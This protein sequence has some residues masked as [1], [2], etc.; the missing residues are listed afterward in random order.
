MGG[1]NNDTYIFDTDLALGTDRIIDTAGI[2]TLDFSATTTRNVSVNLELAG[3]QVINAGLSLRLS[4]S[5]TMENVI[6]GSLNDVILGNSR[7]NRLEGGPGDDTLNGSSGND[8][9]VFDTDSALG[10]DSVEDE[11]GG[12]DILDFS[13]TSTR[14]VDVNLLNGAPQVVNE[15]LTLLLFSAA[16][17][18]Q[19]IGGSLGDR[20][21]GNLLDNILLGMGGD[22]IISG[23]QGRDLII[24][25]T[26][27]D[28]IDGNSGDDLL[29]PGTTRHDGNNSSLR[30][31]LSEWASNRP[32]LE[33]IDNLRNGISNGRFTNVRLLASGVGR[34]VFTDAAVDTLFGSTDDDWYFRAAADQI[35]AITPGE[36]V[37]LLVIS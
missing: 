37:D 18:E 16:R 29:I 10:F 30:T 1:T 13:G 36:V 20:I 27:A 12:I 34:T 4:S 35:G 24:G 5:L 17:M 9:Y 15:G 26:G 31:I 14:P 11:A 25:G 33:R 32:Y 23:G 22:D 21:T 8:T 28:T 7:D 2:D 19:V 3:V 6:G